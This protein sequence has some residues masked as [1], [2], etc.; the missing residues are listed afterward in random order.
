[1]AFPVNPSCTSCG[2]T[3]VVI[4]ELPRRGRL[5]AWTIQHFMPKSPYRSSET[6]ATFMPYGLGYIELPGALRVESRLLENDPGKL[7]IGAEMELAFY[8]HRTEA[9]GTEI[10]NYAFTPI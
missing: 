10:I 2:G 8:V 9:D 5:F 1:M 3:E 4:E 7:M 6:A